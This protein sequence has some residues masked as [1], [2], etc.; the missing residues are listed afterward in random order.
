MEPIFYN[1]YKRITF[2]NCEPLYCMPV[3][4]IILYSNYT[5]V[6][7]VFQRTFLLSWESFILLLQINFAEHHSGHCL[8]FSWHCLRSLISTTHP[9]KVGGSSSTLTDFPLKNKPL[10]VLSL[11]REE[12]KDV[13][14][15]VTL[16]TVK[17]RISI[18][19]RRQNYWFSLL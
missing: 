9:L 10:F 12:K 8:C 11:L 5:L 7:T 3:I 17:P 2:K 16:Y 18:Y 14:L 1:N 4:Y 13:N 6:K 19:E 15:H